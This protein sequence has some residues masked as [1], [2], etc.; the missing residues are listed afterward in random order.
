MFL[1][2]RHMDVWQEM[3]AEV[4]IIG[5]G[6]AGLVIAMELEAAGIASIVLESGGLE[7]EE[8]TRDLNRGTSVGEIDYQFGDGCRSRF[9]GGSS[10]C[11]GGFCRSFEPSDFERRSWVAH[12]GWPLSHGEMQPYV[13]RA[14]E[15][16][17]LGPL[18][19][20]PAHWV[21]A[22]GR[23]DVQRLPLDGSG[24]I[25]AITHFSPPVRFGKTYRHRLRRSRLITVVL[26]ANVVNFDS[27]PDGD[28]LESVQARSLN[29]RQLTVSAPRFVL[30]A[31][32]IE[33]ARLLLACSPRHPGGLANQHGLV[34][35]YFMD[36]PR[37]QVGRIHMS[38]A[39]KR[40][41]L[42]DIK[43]N[44]HSHEVA[45][46]GTKVAA[47]LMPTLALRERLGLTNSV[48]WLCS[49]F[50][51]EGTPQAE[52]LF[53]AKQ[54]SLGHRAWD[55]SVWQDIRTV[56]ADPVTSWRFAAGRV[57]PRWSPAPY[58][59]LACVVEPVPDPDSRVQLGAQ[60]DALGIPRAQVDWR[61]GE[62]EKHTVD[63][64]HRLF[65][66]FLAQSGLGS[67]ELPPPMI[68]RPWPSVFAREGTWHHMGT[69][70]MHANPRQGV[71]DIDCRAHGCKNLYVA[72]SSIFPTA[73]ANYPTINLVALAARLA[74]HL[75]RAKPSAH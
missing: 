25:D 56:L 50:P 7:V 57:I 17:Q 58:I 45:A 72:G 32:G 3:Q 16:L 47:Q 14:H 10:N 31:G 44:Y 62:Q 48:M 34:G 42:Y 6:T 20:D 67:A 41:K 36:H 49:V 59:D 4:C 75:V 71:V 64:G 39:W 66:G 68:G 13:Q 1:D 11:W 37:V 65:A 60:R 23:S 46:G 40:S 52:A 73:G 61:V 30:A 51:G 12:S 63:A 35:R 24:L 69:T 33:N 18:N 2:L 29:Q 22:I 70:R 26:H 43:F 53:R 54:R 74:D 5:G 55:Q 8:A 38:G 15:W 27:D 19:Y 9:L 21:G 28:R